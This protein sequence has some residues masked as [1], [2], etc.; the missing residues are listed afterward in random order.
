MCFTVFIVYIL[1]ILCIPVCTLSIVFMG[2]AAR[3]KINDDDDDD[4]NKVV[5]KRKVTVA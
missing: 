1:H 5:T 4:D 3:F 2:L